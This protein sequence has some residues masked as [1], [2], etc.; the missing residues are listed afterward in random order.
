MHLM[1]IQE[2][3]ESQFLFNGVAI[4]LAY[5]LTALWCFDV[6]RECLQV[7]YSVCILLCDLKKDYFNSCLLSAHP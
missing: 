5:I 1:S 3:S 4:I 7:Y 2:K 6:L